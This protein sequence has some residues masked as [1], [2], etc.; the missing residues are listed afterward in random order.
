MSWT[1]SASLE[2]ITLGGIGHLR[3]AEGTGL[4]ACRFLAGS[5]ELFGLEIEP[6]VGRIS[7]VDSPSDSVDSRVIVPA[8]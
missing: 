7:G 8:L 6:V 5:A 1:E 2:G 4:W 3:F